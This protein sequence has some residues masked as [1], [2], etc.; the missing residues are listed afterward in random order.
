ML[1]DFCHAV[2]TA[3]WCLDDDRI[4]GLQNCLITATKPFHGVTWALSFNE[5]SAKC[6]SVA[7]AA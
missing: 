1:S 6:R 3:G 4:A 5:Q 7:E 2:A